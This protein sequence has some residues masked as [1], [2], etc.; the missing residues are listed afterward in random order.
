MKRLLPAHPGFRLLFLSS[1]AT[2]FGDGLFI[3]SSI[4]IVKKISNNVTALSWM[5]ILTMVPSI[6][7]APFAGAVIDRLEKRTLALASLVARAALIATTAGLLL[8]DHASL[9]FVYAAIILNDT[10]Y[11]FLSPTTDSIT[12][13]LLGED[14]YVRGESFMQGAW[15]VGLM[16][17]SLAAGALMTYLGTAQTMLCAAVAYALAAL[18]LWRLRLSS[19]PQAR[20][21]VAAAE[22]GWLRD[23]QQ[24]WRY[25]QGR[26]PLFYASLAASLSLPL[27]QALNILIAPFNE[28]LLHGTPMTLGFIDAAVSTGGILSA[29]ICVGLAQRRQLGGVTMIALALLAGSLVLFVSSRSVPLAIVTYTAVG[30]FAGMFKVLSKSIVYRHVEA[31]FVGRAM[32]TISMA[33]LII[34][35]GV[36][37]LVGFVGER[38]LSGAYFLLAGF[39]FVPAGLIALAQRKV[40]ATADASGVV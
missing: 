29:M 5:F 28:D 9:V 18:I 16:F 40:A 26:G 37:L 13:E 6:V 25:V 24:G 39:L 17:S 34:S 36:S 27:M 7:L 35:I 4:L 31:A 22:A 1:L 3:L 15:Q 38:S 2:L 30:T 8:T 11:Y 21:P 19:R 14:E 10:F 33:S 32:T 23:I 12:R 20:E